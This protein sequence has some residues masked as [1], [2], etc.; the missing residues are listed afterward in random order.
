MPLGIVDL[1]VGPAALAAIA[2]NMEVNFRA[3]NYDAP[4][5]RASD[6]ASG[7]AWTL[8]GLPLLVAA[9]VPVSLNRAGMVRSSYLAG[10]LALVL[11]YAINRVHFAARTPPAEAS[12][13]MKAPVWVMALPPVVTLA[14][15]VGYA[16]LGATGAQFAY[17]PFA[18]ALFT[19]AHMTW[20]HLFGGR[21]N[22]PRPIARPAPAAKS[23]R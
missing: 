1:T 12:W 11:T 14:L 18:A 6:T 21:A 17:V 22:P 13:W 20:E 7:R 23:N 9:A 19:A 4:V 2:S 8:Y 5:I 16:W 15:A 10:W 3:E